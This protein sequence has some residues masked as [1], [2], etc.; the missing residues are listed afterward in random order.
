MKRIAIALALATGVVAC[1]GNTTSLGGP[2]GTQ[3]S[4]S[5]TAEAAADDG[6]PP[7]PDAG[8]AADAADTLDCFGYTWFPVAAPA[9]CTY[10][11]PSRNHWPDY[12]PYFDP[13]DPQWNPAHV[14]VDLWFFEPPQ[15]G[16]RLEPAPYAPSI[17]SCPAEGGWTYDETSI[18][19]E[20]LHTRYVLCPATCALV[21]DGANMRF[22]AY[23]CGPR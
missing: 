23:G 4:A 12:A 9:A 19:A 10:A 6:A 8:D 17:A 15:T 21:L 3:P 18:D 16:R 13:R 20:G 22:S 1:L 11:L 2:E 7:D 5:S 14:Y